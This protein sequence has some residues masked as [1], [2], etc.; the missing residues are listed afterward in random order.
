MVLKGEPLKDFKYPLLLSLSLISIHGIS[1][2]DM[3]DIASDIYM[4]GLSLFP[5]Y[6]F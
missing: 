6:G 5:I 2:F 1:V 3:M 4:S